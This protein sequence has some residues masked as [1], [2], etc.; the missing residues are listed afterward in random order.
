[1]PFNWVW[2]YQDMLIDLIVPV[3]RWVEA[4]NHGSVRLSSLK[5][6]ILNQANIGLKQLLQETCARQFQ[7]VFLEATFYLPVECCVFVTAPLMMAVLTLDIDLRHSD[8]LPSFLFPYL[9]GHT[10]CSCLPCTIPTMPLAPMIH[11]RVRPSVFIKSEPLQP[12][13]PGSDQR[14]FSRSPVMRCAEPL[15]APLIF[16]FSHRRRSQPHLQLNRPPPAHPSAIGSGAVISHS[17]V[18]PHTPYPE[19]LKMPRKDK[20]RLFPDCWQEEKEGRGLKYLTAMRP[21]C[22][23]EILFCFIF[24]AGKLQRYTALPFKSQRCHSQ[25]EFTMTFSMLGKDGECWHGICSWG[26]ALIYAASCSFIWGAELWNFWK[27][28]SGFAQWCCFQDHKARHTFSV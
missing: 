24:D 22:N 27:S 10:H 19:S 16:L 6:A 3:S 1:M 25:W 8:S 12:S 20:E 18:F 7:V 15:G 14:S 26:R 11:G 2:Q 4:I 17:D 9:G 23:E 13:A 28:G 21:L 5:R